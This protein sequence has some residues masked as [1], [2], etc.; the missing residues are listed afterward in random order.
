MGIKKRAHPI[1]A[2]GCLGPQASQSTQSS[3]GFEGERHGGEES[4]ELANSLIARDDLTSSEKQNSEE[5]EAGDDI[6]HCRDH[7]LATGRFDF[8]LNPPVQKRAVPVLLIVFQSVQFDRVDAVKDLVQTC[9]HAP[10]DLAGPPGFSTHVVLHQK[11][12]RDEKW[13]ADQRNQ[14]PLP[15]NGKRHAEQC[16]Q[17]NGVSARAK[18]QLLPDFPYGT[19]VS[20]HTFDQ[21]AWRM[22]LVEQSIER[23]QVGHQTALHFGLGTLRDPGQDQLLPDRSQRPGEEDTQNTKTHQ[24]DR[25]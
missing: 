9:R 6:D 5:A 19:H 20:L 17:G 21:I 23:H 2:H 15:V 25:I 12:G 10:R 22:L 3:Q 7:G 18:D 1:Q 24:P 4:H 8:N 14:R 16:N 13:D 11:G